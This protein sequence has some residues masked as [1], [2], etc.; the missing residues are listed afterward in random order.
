MGNHR[1]GLEKGFQVV[2]RPE[3]PHR[4]CKHRYVLKTDDGAIISLATDGV[5]QISPELYFKVIAGE[6]V[7]PALYYFKEHLF[8]ETSVKKYQWINA[9]VAFSVVGIKPTGEILNKG[10]L[11]LVF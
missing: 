1:R 4:K 3:R 5:A 9:V 10:T 11:N 7:D 8:F 2:T 6:F